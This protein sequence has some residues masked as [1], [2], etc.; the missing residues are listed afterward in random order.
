MRSLDRRGEVEER[1]LFRSMLG[2]GAL[3][4]VGIAA[5][6]ATGSFAILFDGVYSL[7]DTS[8]AA[9]A[10]VVA[11]L[12]LRDARAA[13]APVDGDAAHPGPRIQ[14][15]YWHLEPLVVVLNATLL[16]AAALYALLGAVT[17]LREGGSTPDFGPA[18]VYAGAVGAFCFAMAAIQKRAA[19]RA[20]SALAALDAKSWIISG[21]ITLALFAGF[22]AGWL[23][24]GTR[25]AWLQPY[26]DSL[27]LIAVCLVVLPMP[28]A[29]LREGLRGVLRAAPADLDHRVRAAAD[30]AV[31]RHGLSHAYAHAARVGRS[32]L[33]E[34]SFVVPPDWPVGTIARLDAIRAEISAAIGGE[35]PD[36]WMTI[37]F[38]GQDRWAA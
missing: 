26:V 21:S 11:R 27:I 23:A 4:L 1:L 33:V 22:L 38:T 32:T 30:A 5:G 19:E 14:F 17:V 24:G 31:D 12:I 8:M 20:A 9:L 16:I 3:A 15:G 28:L 6:I 10:W 34:I 18:L 36:R 35:G 2:T 37:T 29:D 7:I 25:L 13:P